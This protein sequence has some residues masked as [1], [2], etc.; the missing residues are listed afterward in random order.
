MYMN[1]HVLSSQIYDSIWCMAFLKALSQ[2]E[3]D[4][5]QQNILATSKTR[6][7]FLIVA[8]IIV[9]DEVFIRNSHDLKR[10]LCDAHALNLAI[11][12]TR[13]S[14]CNFLINECKYY[15]IAT[16]KKFS[17]LFFI[18]KYFLW[19]I[20]EVTS[21]NLAIWFTVYFFLNLLCSIQRF[22]SIKLIVTPFCFVWDHT[23]PI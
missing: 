4:L 23:V 18:V 5:K 15:K 13:T 8:E 11:Y 21:A 6:F 22:F 16:K 20:N 7:R 17:D 2:F 9:Y 19:Y 12:L 1:I 10:L 3:H 14:I